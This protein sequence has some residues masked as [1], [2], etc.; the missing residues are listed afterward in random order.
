MTLREPKILKPTDAVIKL[1]TICICGTDLPMDKLDTM[2]VDHLSDRLFTPDRL[3]DVLS[4][5][6]QRRVEK[7]A[8]IGCRIAALETEAIEA[9]DKLKRL[10]RMVERR[11]R[12]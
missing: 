5:L 11:C 2:V 12:T 6:A 9:E 4:S 7:D 1:P 10:Y 8:E 3:T